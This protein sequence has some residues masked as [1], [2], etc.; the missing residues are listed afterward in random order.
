[1]FNPLQTLRRVLFA[2]CLML[3]SGAAFAGPIYHVTVDTAGL[4]GQGFL[5]FSVIG[6]QGA[7]GAFATLSNF[8]GAFGAE[9]DRVGAVAGA[10]P[11]GFTVA[12]GAGDNW[13]TQSVSLGGVFAF[14]IAF[15][16]DY[17]T[18]QGIDGATFAVSLYDELF[19][20][21]TLVATFAAQPGSVLGAASLTP[22]AL[23]AGAAITPVPEPSNLLLVLTAL[24]VV[25]ALRLR[26]L[27]ATQRPFAA[28]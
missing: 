22:E 25:G 26:S 27:T 14:D 21:Q 7:P 28:I 24:L 4:T 1:M 5:D 19:S 23:Y 11:A 10:I 15:G 12:N 16:G 17:E 18:V 8:S 2:L 6:T 13:L 20:A 9:A 3:G